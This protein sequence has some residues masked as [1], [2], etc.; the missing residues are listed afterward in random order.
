LS[1]KVEA[2][3]A[4]VKQLVKEKSSKPQNDS[5]LDVLVKT[6]E[7]NQSK[8]K[9]GERYDGSLKK[10]SRYVFNRIGP[11]Q[12]QLFRANFPKAL[13]SQTTLTRIQNDAQDVPLEGQFRFK[14][15][16]EFLSSR[17]DYPKVIWALEDGTRITRRVEY[18]KK[19]NQLTGFPVPLDSAGRPKV[20][21]FPA[22]SA[23]EIQD[24]FENNAP[25][26][27][28][29]LV[30]AQPLYP[31]ATPF[32]LAIFGTDNKFTAMDVTSR[33]TWMKE[34]A[35]K[36]GIEILGF[37]SD[38]DSRLLRTMMNVTFPKNVSIK[39][40]WF[41]ADLDSAYLCVQDNIHIGTKLR[42]RLLRNSSLLPMGDHLVSVSHI[43]E[44]IR[45]V[46]KDHHNIQE[47]DLIA[48][49]KMNFRAMEKLYEENVTRLLREKVPSSA[50]TATYLDMAREVLGSYLD[51]GLTPLERIQMIFKWIFFLR[52]WKAWLKINGLDLQE[53]F[54]SSNCY[55]CIE[56]NGHNLI[57]CAR[58]LRKTNRS[59]LFVTWL[60]NSQGCEGT[61]RCLRSMTTTRCTVVNFSMRDVLHRFRR[62]EFQSNTEVE[63]NGVFK[64]PS[65]RRSSQKQREVGAV[66]EF[67][68]PTDPEIEKVVNIAKSSAIEVAQSLGMT[69]ENIPVPSFKLAP[70]G[71]VRN[72][73][74]DCFSEDDS[75]DDEN[76]PAVG[77]V[78]DGDRGNG[79]E[80]MSEND[81]AVEENLCVVSSGA[82]G[83]KTFTNVDVSPDSIYVRVAD[84]NG[85]PVI[86]KKSTL[87]YL[88]SQKSAK[89]SSDRLVR[90]RA[91][92]AS[93][94]CSENQVSTISRTAK[95]SEGDWCAFATVDGTSYLLGRVL[96]FANLRGGTIKEKSYR[97]S[98]VSVD[99]PTKDNGIGC[100]CT[101]YHIQ[102]NGTLLL[103][104][105]FSPGYH[106]LRFY[107]CTVPRPHFVN[108]VL[109]VKGGTSSDINSI[110]SSLSF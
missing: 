80:S 99:V 67:S 54:I 73:K 18:H 25:C 56:V 59:Q 72:T 106:N 91:P 109:H 40:T 81:N 53:N 102:E 21:S 62:I 71:A 29:Y 58:N 20:G 13:P 83:V 87:C 8:K 51:V 107:I 6:S 49:D 46:T 94:Q 22:R 3:E 86:I 70:L 88:L 79:T 95:V 65:S 78:D 50:A 47:T 93:Q 43:R 12:Y 52:I 55:N 104:K 23:A 101:W 34:A 97:Q 110:F 64:F 60:M 84:G 42:T 85:K 28:A 26:G 108:G 5:L 74:D 69:V 103:D 4:K 90:V 35:A 16:S 45:T 48:T 17:D 39:W 96:D 76:S 89:L 57:L 7:H 10:M 19:T 11:S 75:S 38:G 27:Y 30:I 61:F 36:H 68:L 15:L 98:S 32:I 105:T 82:M 41:V 31:N 24:H 2:A 100:L 44:L 66:P 37:S 63:L 1:L 33:W 77:V 14:E 9:G 92:V